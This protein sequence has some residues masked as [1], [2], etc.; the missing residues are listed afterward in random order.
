MLNNKRERKLLL[1]AYN[2]L[3]S[4]RNLLSICASFIQRNK[5]LFLLLCD[6]IWM[7]GSFYACQRDTQNYPK[8]ETQRFR[9][10]HPFTS[11]VSEA[12]CIPNLFSPNKKD[13][14]I[15]TVHGYLPL[16]TS[17]SRSITLSAY[18]NVHSSFSR[19]LLRAGGPNIIFL[20]E[21]FDSRL[22]Q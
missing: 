20:T 22:P 4:N 7:A 12:F 18:K 16:P 17:G 10:A 2:K 5:D 21:L 9:N 3:K 6:F 8:T 11:I 19:C 15:I 1:N 13:A 14:G